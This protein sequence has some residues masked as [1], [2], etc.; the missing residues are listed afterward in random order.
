MGNLISPFWAVVGAN[1][2]KVDFRLLFGYRLIFAALW[3]GIGVIVFTLL[4]C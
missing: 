4:P 2:A 3:F 1:I